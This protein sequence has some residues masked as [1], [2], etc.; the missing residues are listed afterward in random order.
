MGCNSL[1]SL[2][3]VMFS[4]Y[5]TESRRLPLTREAFRQNILLSHY[6]ALQWKSSHVSSPDLPDPK[7]FGWCWDEET[8]SYEGIMT[9]L[10]PAPESV[11]DLSL[12]RCKTKCVSLRCVC[13]KNG[14]SC[15]EMCFCENCEN[16]KN[17]SLCEL[18]YEDDDI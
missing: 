9:T 11:I 1:A 17:D 13:R 3:W 5:Q 10:P 18:D 12:C 8:Y 16:C 4:K 2:K 7:D 14:M 15:S 6:T